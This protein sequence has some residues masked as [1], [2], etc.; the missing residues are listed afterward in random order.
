MSLSSTVRGKSSRSGFVLV[1]VVFLF[2][3][4]G[5]MM[6]TLS[7]LEAHS[8]RRVT[9]WGQQSQLNSLVESATALA[10]FHLLHKGE[11]GQGQMETGDK[12][13]SATWA[14]EALGKDRFAIKA[15]SRTPLS[16]T[17]K[18]QAEAVSYFS[19]KVDKGEVT[20]VP[21]VP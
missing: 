14:I 13:L 6:L 19:R 4:I 3:V 11:P 21:F 5:V 9:Y 17:L 20:L 10:R 15:K 7:T 2:S 18:F 16:G 8:A 1:G 12:A